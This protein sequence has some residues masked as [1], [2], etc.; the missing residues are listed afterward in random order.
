MKSIFRKHML[1]FAA[2]AAALG[3]LSLTA[4]AEEPAAGGEITICYPQEL[5]SHVVNTASGS[6]V[7]KQQKDHK[8]TNV[9]TGKSFDD[10]AFL[11]HVRMLETNYWAR[12]ESEMIL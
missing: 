2:A 11:S 5:I 12:T 4:M 3:A 10:P 8:D 7:L 9:F 6:E 1:G